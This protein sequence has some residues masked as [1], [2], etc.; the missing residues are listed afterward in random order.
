[1][2]IYG[3]TKHFFG[4]RFPSV[5]VSAFI[6]LTHFD[7]DCGVFSKYFEIQRLT[8]SPKMLTFFS[9]LI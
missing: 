2:R 8:F 9:H 3:L 6:M 7:L 4:R 5:V 1:M